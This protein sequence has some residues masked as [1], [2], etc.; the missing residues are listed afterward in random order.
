M[1]RV[2]TSD[3]RRLLTLRG[4]ELTLRGKQSQNAEEIE[5]VKAEIAALRKKGV[6]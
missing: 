1:A 5:K 2:K 6:K 4:K 3:E